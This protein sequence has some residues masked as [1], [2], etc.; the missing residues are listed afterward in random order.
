MD[1]Q[2]T[3][4]AAAAGQNY[5]RMISDFPDASS[6][7]GPSQPSSQAAP[8]NASQADADTCRICRGDGSP[9]EPLFY[10]CKCS[11][12]IKYVHQDCLMEWLS[13]SQ[14]KHCELC[15]TPFR[16]TKLYA[17]NMPKTVPFYVFISHMAKYL[18]RNMLVWARAALVIMVWLVWLPYLMRRIW[19]ALF[20]ISDEGLSPIF[21][22]S[23]VTNI[24]GGATFLSDAA[25]C[26]ANPMAQTCSANPFSSL[27]N[28]TPSGST[29]QGTSL[30]GINITA[31]NP[32][33]NMLLNIF[34]SSFYMGG[35]AFRD[36]ASAVLQNVTA[37]I[38]SQH[39]SLLSGV[40]FLQK[41]SSSSP[42]L[43]GFV[44]DVF[45]GQI[46]TVVVVI[47][48]ILIILVRDYVVQQQPD[49]NLRA[50]FA[51]ADNGA[52]REDAEPADAEIPRLVP[53]DPTE[54]L[55][56][57]DI[58]G[59]AGPEQEDDETSMQAVNGDIEEHDSTTEASDF[60][61]GDGEAQ[62]PLIQNAKRPRSANPTD[63]SNGPVEDIS[64][65][66]DILREE[67]QEEDPAIARAV[68]RLKELNEE[69]VRL[70][71]LN[72]ARARSL[73]TLEAALQATLQAKASS[74]SDDILSGD[75]ESSQPESWRPR[76]EWDWPQE[77]SRHSGK[78]KA[79][80]I[81]ESRDTAEGQMPTS[82]PRSATDGPQTLGGVNRL[83]HNNWSFSESH[84]EGPSTLAAADQPEDA[85]WGYLT[86]PPSMLAGSTPSSAGD[87][88][89]SSSDAGGLDNAARRLS[90]QTVLNP[91]DD[92]SSTQTPE[93]WE[94]IADLDLDLEPDVDPPREPEAA[95]DANQQQPAGGIAQRVADFMWRDVEA[96]PPHELPPIPDPADDFFDHDQ[97]MA[98]VG[99]IEDHLGE[100]AE[101]DAEVLAAA[102]AAG[103]DAE[104]EAIEDAEDLEGVLELL[105]M[106]GPIAG[107]FQNALFC[108][109]LV[110]ITLVT[111]VFLPYNLGRLSIWMVANPI[112][113]IRMVISLS[114]TVQDLA[115][116]LFGFMSAL[117]LSGFRATVAFFQ[118]QAT[119]LAMIQHT[120]HRSWDLMENAGGSLR[121]SGVTDFYLISTD[122]VRNFSMVSHAALLSIKSQ[123]AMVLSSI[124][125]GILFIFGGD[126]AIKAAAVLSWSTST[127]SLVWE[128]LGKL[129]AL[130]SSSWVIDLGSPDMV[131]HLDPELASWGAM[132]R[133]WV[134]LG[135][136][137]AMCGITGLYLGR[138]SPIAGRM[139][140]E[141]EATIIELLVQASGVMKVILII[142]IEMLVFP[143]YCGLLLDV[144]LLP[145]FED[146]TVMSRV[147]FTIN[148]PLTSVFVHW[149][150]GTGYMFHFALFVSM[151]RKIMR[152]GVLCT[153]LICAPL[154]SLCSA[155]IPSRLHP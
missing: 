55:E 61:T 32:L 135:G 94:A 52:P 146:A 8:D 101:R 19:S 41:I 124:A 16:F 54:G 65:Y 7:R 58:D 104:A 152:K 5:R 72:E 11:G 96:I 67:A 48:F 78:G 136:Y 105:G 64:R 81:D 51:A 119:M 116:L 142:G 77:E 125:T 2:H 10:P 20:W 42:A 99:A 121:D 110:T 35:A 30:Y 130:T 49:I 103:I 1:D 147:M 112:R 107:L 36:N 83:A 40:R 133:L 137:L 15:K 95:P 24:T 120:V 128:N 100:L 90:E 80:L 92:A 86:P 89:P 134:I 46:I 82:R 3:V 68:A 118:P 71:E 70:E 117:A 18:F 148:Y 129:P 108:A 25:I 149:F 33:S 143:L 111:G 91:A 59:L 69:R 6:S 45:E 73:A 12:S 39:P 115:M 122:E 75:G 131:L 151:C 109:F 57:G 76:S 127:S 153:Y 29:S 85:R 27:I 102:A 22:K 155:N 74:S 79:P 106:R 66:T 17:P 132:D 9:E 145:L 88:T 150:V 154:P 141:W 4:G 114:K 63:R 126:Y 43:G 113:P 21:G 23:D 26:P 28:T 87:Q 138:G 123:V 34:L 38:L 93:D 47:C 50:A 31:D 13:H 44:I 53:V 98:L 84:Q 97:D 140:Q 139:G 62:L 60:Y 14:K 56:E 37:P 144:A